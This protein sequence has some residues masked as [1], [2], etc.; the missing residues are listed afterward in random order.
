MNLAKFTLTSLIVSMLVACGGGSPGQIVDSESGDISV[1]TP[2]I[3]NGEGSDYSD[4]LIAV[5]ES[6]LVNGQLSAGGQ[7]TIS[8]DIVDR[9]SSNA[10]IVGTEYGVI[11]SST[12]ANADPALASFGN[13]ERV[14]SSGTVTTTY[15]AEGCSGTDTITAVLYN[16]SDGATDQNSSLATAKVNIDVVSPTVNSISYV[17]ATAKNLGLA[18]V[19]NTNLP[20]VSTLTF[21]VAD[22]NDDAVANQTVEFS[23]T[24]VAGSASLSSSS[25]ITN[26][27]GEVTVVVNAGTSHAVVRVK[28]SIDFL[29]ENDVEATTQTFSEPISIGTGL[30]V[31][32]G[33]TISASIFNPM[34]IEEVGTEV[35][36]TAYLN[37]RYRNSPPDGTV[38]NFT[39][40]GGSI[41]D[42]P[43]ETQN[44]ACSVIWKSQ[45]PIPGKGSLGA[46]KV[47]DIVGFSTVMAYTQ[48]D[49]DYI[50]RNANGV[51]DDAE[52]FL[53]YGEAFRDDDYDG[54][55]HLDED[56]F[57]DSDNDGAYTEA[58]A[59][60]YQG[61]LCSDGAIASGHCASNI[62]VSK[63]LRLVM[64]GEAKKLRVFT[65]DA[66]TYTEVDVEGGDAMD[67]SKKHYVVIQDTNGNIPA[68]GTS[69]SFNA[70]GL[71]ITSDTGG[72]QNSIGLLD[73]IPGWPAGVRGAAYQVRFDDDDNGDNPS[74]PVLDVTVSRVID[75]NGDLTFSVPLSNVAAP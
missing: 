48:G 42:S 35:S 27:N 2:D 18:S 55:H 30:P 34:S 43:C 25:S 8:I 66:G 11:F 7:V 64:S 32:S 60:I 1:G 46:I 63:S 68:K 61:S 47:N 74:S 37:D 65:L 21:S 10:R 23:I 52:T 16:T 17:S 59:S 33:M 40:E 41:L 51:F 67:S 44:G 12:C 72:V 45:N 73:E 69:V 56:F 4:A 53:S 22:I 26:S 75:G 24:P 38:I 50:D 6:G 15:S 14:T 5:D 31:Q 9:A 29:N 71:E 36:I 3:G 13:A 49:A 20:K 57:I 28:A 54:V 19:G 62:I 70:E 58:D 39:T